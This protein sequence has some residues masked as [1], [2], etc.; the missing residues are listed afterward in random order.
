M[1]L[2]NLTAVELGKKIKNKEVT[3]VEATK[4][5]LDAID[6]K[7]EKV[8]SFVTVDREG[9][10]K[11][12]EEVQKLI[13]EGKL[14]GPLAGVPVAVKDNMC[15]EGMLTTCSSKI[16]GNFVPTFTSEAV[17][18]LEKAGAVILGKTNMDEFA[19][20]STTE[21]SAYG[22]TKNPWNLEH[23]PGGSSGGSCAAVAAEECFYALGSDTGGSIR[24]PSSFCGV[25]G[26]K[27][28]YGTVSRYG[29]I[30]YGSSLDQIGPVAKDVTDCAAILEVIASH[31]EKD[32]TSVKRDDLDFTS[33]LVDDVKGM[34]IG[35]PKDYFGEGLDSE[36]KDAVLNAAKVLEQKG[37]I[38]EEFDL[39][40][41]EYAIPAYYVI[42]CAEASSNL[43]RFDGV[44]YG[45]RTDEYDGLHNMYKKSRS[46]G[47]GAEVKRRIM[48]GSFVLSSGYYDAYYL[49]ALRTKALIKKAFDDA[50]AK[51]DVI[52]GPAAP[53][54]APKL[55]ESL[56]DPLKMYLGDIYTISV[57]LAGL[58]GITVPCGMDS[59]GLPIGLQ[60]IGDCF[61]EKNIIRAAYSFEQTREFKHSPL[62]D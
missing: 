11:R 55:G 39:S 4:A 57:N 42:A 40:L 61:K 35:I 5:A 60:L 30:A 34:K 19:M 56:S 16:L 3:V 22:E 43:A 51:Y 44:K 37:A 2:M 28:T 13:D 25:T 47:F 7:E 46:E 14:A 53:T 10:L 62:A 54:T 20:G 59:N 23:V 8:N 36:V 45:Y 48:L 9:A 21:T 41:V 18:N 27:P 24:Q 33:A 1:S 38:V 26:I 29:L 52:L 32:S 58:P 50:F 49:K 15:T 17:I 31:D 6:A 12:A